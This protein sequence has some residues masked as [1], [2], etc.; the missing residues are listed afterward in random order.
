MP[1][2]PINSDSRSKAGGAPALSCYMNVYQPGWWHGY[3][4]YWWCCCWK[5]YLPKN[6]C[7]WLIHSNLQLN[8]TPFQ[9]H[10]ILLSLP[11]KLFCAK[12][13]VRLLVLCS[14]SIIIYLENISLVSTNCSTSSFWL[15]F[16]PTSHLTP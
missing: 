15:G 12:P 16:Y 4:M 3:F 1:I 9:T 11:P 13:P 7:I 6:T 5:F 8:M 14:Q 2:S 10:F